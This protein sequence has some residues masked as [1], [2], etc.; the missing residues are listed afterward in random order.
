MFE[1]LLHRSSRPPYSV[2]TWIGRL[3]ETI[4][5]KLYILIYMHKHNIICIIILHRSTTSHPH[6]HRGYT[7]YRGRRRQRLSA[8]IFPFRTYTRKTVCNIGFCRWMLRKRIWHTAT[9]HFSI[10]NEYIIYY[11][12]KNTVCLFLQTAV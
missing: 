12:C 10:F 2:T 6:A 4:F 7:R 11:I 8:I 5:H 3:H 9:I 1:P